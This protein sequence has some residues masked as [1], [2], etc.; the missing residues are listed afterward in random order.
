M[1]DRRPKVVMLCSF[2]TS[3]F[4]I[5]NA[6]KKDVDIELVI[7]ERPSGLINKARKKFKII[8]NRS[9]RLGFNTVFGQLLFKVFETFYLNKKSKKRS[10]DVIAQYDLDDAVPEI[11]NYRVISSVK[12]EKIINYVAEVGP[13]VVLVNGT[14]ILSASIIDGIKCPIINTHVGITPKY[15][16][17][18]GGYWA[19]ANDDIENFGVTVHLIDPGIDT[20]GVLYQER[21]RI[22]KEDTF[23]TYPLHQI[24]IA[25]PLIVKSLYDAASD[26]LVVKEK[27]KESF[28][29]SHPTLFQ[30]I[31]NWKE[32]GVK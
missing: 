8:K 26:N 5:F 30:Y 19:L 24:G 28:L 9:K 20:G 27:E 17:S 31:R 25:M 18:H 32:K 13:D 21:T 10:N 11:E 2:A 29:W 22:T 6:I 16:G 7:Y 1:K 3:S 4:Y 12:D 15:R 23:K 14:G